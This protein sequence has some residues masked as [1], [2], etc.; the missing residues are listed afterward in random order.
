LPDVIIDPIVFDDAGA[1][2]PVTRLYVTTDGVAASGERV[3]AA[4]QAADPT[5]WVAIP[6]GQVSTVPQFAEVARIV[7]LGLIGSLLLAGCSLAVATMTGL[8]ERRRE[9]TFLRAAGMPVSRL[10]VLVLLQAGVPLI[11]VSSFSALL[12]V[13]AAQAI[14]RMATVAEVPLPDPSLLGVLGV[15]LAVAMAVVVAT[16]PAVDGLTRPTSLRSE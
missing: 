10:R 14:L 7:G 12:G 13:I 4:I 15:S 9:Y 2:F 3:R 1:G 16:L 11:V 5:A 6:T 8:L